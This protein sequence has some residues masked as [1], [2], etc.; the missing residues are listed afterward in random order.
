MAIS[1]SFDIPKLTN[2]NYA[3]WS[4]LMKSLLVLKELWSAVS[5]EGDVKPGA[6]DK[7]LALLMLNVSTSH[8]VSI[9]TAK[10]AKEAWEKLENVYKKKSVARELEL[11]RQLTLLRKEPTEELATYV[12]RA[13]ELRDQLLMA[14]H[15]IPDREVVICLLNGLPEEFNTTIEFL[16]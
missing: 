11:R 4:D 7:A 12:S 5:G 6:E 13:T 9:R 10:T 3:E 8:R 15:S 2:D 16:E 1:G 14:G